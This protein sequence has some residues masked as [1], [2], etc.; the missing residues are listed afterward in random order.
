M[1]IMAHTRIRLSSINIDKLNEIINAVKE[2]S[3][4]SGV[5]M[6]GVTVSGLCPYTRHRF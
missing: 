4:R 5:V 3:G 6:R 2:I 1:L